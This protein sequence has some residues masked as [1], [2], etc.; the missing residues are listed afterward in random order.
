MRGNGVISIFLRVNFSLGMVRPQRCWI[1]NL[2]T[3]VVQTSAVVIRQVSDIRCRMFGIGYTAILDI[4]RERFLR[5]EASP[6][7]F[8]LRPSVFVC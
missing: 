7:I 5:R 2:P 6:S 8:G 3:N 1:G 4:G